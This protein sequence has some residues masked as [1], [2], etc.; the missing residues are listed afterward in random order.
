[1]TAAALLLVLWLL[2]AP[3]AADAAAGWRWPVRGPLLEAFRMH[4]QRFAP[5]QHRGI[6]IGAP[7]GAEVVA[8][9]G[10]RVAFAGHAGTSGLVVSVVCGPL[11]A[12]YLHLASVVVARGDV[13][14]AGSSLGAVGR[15][16]RPG[17]RHPHLHL[18]A[19]RT[20]SRWA[21]VDP[22]TLLG[23]RPSAPPVTVPLP[24]RWRPG[25][26]AL[27]PAPR[28]ERA[29]DSRRPR[30][31]PAAPAT[32]AAAPAPGSPWYAWAGAA[33]AALAVPGRWCAG[34]ARRRRRAGP[35]ARGA[36]AA[37]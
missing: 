18:G 23:R 7:I 32:A 29:R 22:L 37:R 24:G 28:P 1:M 11:T 10:G 8:A 12:T 36:R 14:A 19:R 33:L 35:A 4:P 6:D 25:P 5:G 9:C 17:H 13:V 31:A 16:G 20:G 3:A 27:G 34:V 30:A 21:Y 15:S 26:P 2:A